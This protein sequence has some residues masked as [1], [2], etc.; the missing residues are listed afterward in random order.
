MWSNVTVEIL[1][2][3]IIVF[4]PMILL[5][6]IVVLFHL[7]SGHICVY[8]QQQETYLYKKPSDEQNYLH[9]KLAQYPV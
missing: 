6:A 4:V 9:A 7:V 2:K 1:L 8:Q 3:T 5:K